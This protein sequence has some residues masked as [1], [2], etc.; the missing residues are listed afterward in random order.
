MNTKEL[1]KYQYWNGYRNPILTQERLTKLINVMGSDWKRRVDLTK[2][3]KLDH[4]VTGTVINL[5]LKYELI[6]ARIIPNWFFK[7]RC[8]RKSRKGKIKHTYYKLTRYG[9]QETNILKNILRDQKHKNL[10]P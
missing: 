7:Q 4:K 8:T 9:K 6:Q 10:E 1:N 3:T 5:G 2:L